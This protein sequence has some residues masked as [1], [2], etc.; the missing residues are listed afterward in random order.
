MY[1]PYEVRR[2]REIDYISFSKFSKFIV[3]AAEGSL[4]QHRLSF[5]N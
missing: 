2:K 1:T 4:T 5:L 3:I